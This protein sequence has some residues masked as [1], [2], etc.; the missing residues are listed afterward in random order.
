MPDPLDTDLA[1]ALPAPRATRLSELRVAVWSQQQ[2]HETDAETVAL[3]EDL[4]KHLETEG[5]KV[6]RTARPDFDVE[7]GV[8][9]LHYAARCGAQCAR[10]G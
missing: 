8:P 2:G 9:A 3:I 10:A 5:A 7:R 1:I 6:N 4:A